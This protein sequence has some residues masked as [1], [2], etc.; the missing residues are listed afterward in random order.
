MSI[1]L[2]IFNIRKEK[3]ISLRKL[4]EKTNIARGN[5]QKLEKGILN[6]PTLATL[7]KIASGLDIPLTDLFFDFTS[8]S[9][10]LQEFLTDSK[11]LRLMNV[12]AEEI[13]WLKTVRFRISQKPSKETY[14]SLLDIYRNSFDENI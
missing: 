7:E 1:K 5:I 14:I 13:E 9:Y 4:E 3:G 10:G 2:N 11:L 8:Y 6:N 12:K